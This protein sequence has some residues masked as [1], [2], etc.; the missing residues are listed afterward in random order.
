[1]DRTLVVHI[2]DDDPGVRDSVGVMLEAVGYACEQYPSASAFL[3]AVG[4]TRPGCA[5]VDIRM[6]GMDGL[7][8]QKEML[9][10][11][12]HLPIIFMT[13]FAD[14][15]LAVTAMKNGAIDFVEKP[16]PLEALR[17][18]IDRA[19]ALVRKDRS[20]PSETLEAQ[21]RFSCLTPREQEVLDCLVAGDLNKTA[22]HKLGISPR[23]V[24][25]H[26]AHIME[27]VQVK[28]LADLVR[29]A[30]A[31]GPFKRESA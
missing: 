23:T 27:K 17:Q 28:S 1:M 31:A 18:A 29:L 22:A 25:L 6:P 10:R 8:L 2:V 11:G 24:E 9:A 26:R 13:G 14:V 12:L 21:S 5:L 7:A 4:M 19:F 30:I 20:A 16:C 15:P 3:G